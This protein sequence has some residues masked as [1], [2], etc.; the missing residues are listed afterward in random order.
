MKEIKFTGEIVRSC[1]INKE[2][3]VVWCYN[4]RDVANVVMYIKLIL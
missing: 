1:E 4:E 2:S 3:K